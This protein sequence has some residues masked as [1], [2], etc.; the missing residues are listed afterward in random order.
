M[1]NQTHCACAGAAATG[2]GDAGCYS[3]GAPPTP[4][5]DGIDFLFFFSTS[6][7]YWILELKKEFG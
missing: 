5:A 7:M 2:A 6:F 4:G 3:N 1:I